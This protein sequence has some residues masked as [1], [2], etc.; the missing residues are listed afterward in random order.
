M[1]REEF[2]KLRLAIKSNDP[3]GKLSSFGNLLEKLVDYVIKNKKTDCDI[4]YLL[5]SI[6]NQ[7]QIYECAEELYENI[8]E[9]H[10]DEAKTLKNLDSLN[11]L[12]CIY[13][14]FIQESNIEEKK[15]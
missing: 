15:E 3:L 2:E 5:E 7:K 1:E 12:L 9:E 6:K 13:E 11:D 14:K 10:F 8:Q 4:N